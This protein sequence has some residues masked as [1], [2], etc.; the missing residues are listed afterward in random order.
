[1]NAN[2]YTWTSP[3]GMTGTVVASS[4][5]AARAKAWHFLCHGFQGYSKGQ[6]VVRK[7]S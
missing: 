5:S 2:K 7:V 1:M 4:V 3:D 6:I